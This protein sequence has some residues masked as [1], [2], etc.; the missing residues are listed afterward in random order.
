MDD[1][2]RACPA[3]PISRSGSEFKGSLTRVPLNL[4]LARGLEG[5]PPKPPLGRGGRASPEPGGESGVVKGWNG[6]V[7]DPP[8]AVRKRVRR[9]VKGASS[10]LDPR[11][12]AVV[13]D[14]V[15]EGDGTGGSGSEGGG[16]RRPEFWS[17]LLLFIKENRLRVDS[18]SQPE[19]VQGSGRRADN[20]LWRGR[21]VLDAAPDGIARWSCGG[22][23]SPK[24]ILC[25]DRPSEHLYATFLALPVYA[26]RSASVRPSGWWS[27]RTA[28]LGRPPSCTLALQSRRLAVAVP[29]DV[30]RERAPI[31]AS[32]LRPWISRSRSAA[33]SQ[34]PSVEASLLARAVEPPPTRPS[35]PQSLQ[36]QQR[37]KSDQILALSPRLEQGLLLRRG[38]R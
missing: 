30:L 12:V 31:L 6:A 15:E 34:G 23:G 13:R 25:R 19:M 24:F 16:P 28:R 35:F 9:E 10:V 26:P 20:V 7:E 2:R 5:G 22:C 17:R 33:N 36:T 21:V 37:D 18:A 11:G 1:R 14:S 8:V 27:Q 32:S 29:T 4:F 38:E 3:R